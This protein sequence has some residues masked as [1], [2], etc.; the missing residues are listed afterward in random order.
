MIVADRDSYEWL[1]FCL[2]V[3]REHHR[4]FKVK[5]GR[6]YNSAPTGRAGRKMSRSIPGQ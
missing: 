6:D 1:L 4:R 2:T 5:A 3:M